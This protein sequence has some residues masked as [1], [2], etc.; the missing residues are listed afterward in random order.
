MLIS[1]AAAEDGSHFEL[2]SGEMLD[3]LQHP[4]GVTRPQ[5]DLHRGDV[6]QEL[7]GGAAEDGTQCGL[8]R[9]EVLGE[10]PGE[11]GKVWA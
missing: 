11:D 9:R 3:Q 5:Q 7:Q 8:Y 2:H 4:D 10:L 6:L 1:G